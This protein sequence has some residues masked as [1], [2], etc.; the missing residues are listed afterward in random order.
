MG[1]R[2]VGSESRSLL[3]FGQGLLSLSII[4][5]QQSKVVPNRRIVR[6]KL[7]RTAQ[8]FIRWGNTRE[9]QQGDA[10]VELRRGIILIDRDRLLELL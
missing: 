8:C 9:I 2:V 4:P 7:C 5:M 6:L 10:K 3:E 1:V